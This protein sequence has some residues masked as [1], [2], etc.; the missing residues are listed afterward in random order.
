MKSRLRNHCEDGHQTWPAKG[1]YT[2]Y[3]AE[4]SRRTRED[5]FAADIGAVRPPEAKGGRSPRL[6]LVDLDTSRPLQRLLQNDIANRQVEGDRQVR[7]DFGSQVE[8]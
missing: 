3:T 4:I 7:V 2:R 1:R 5:N 8:D 6:G